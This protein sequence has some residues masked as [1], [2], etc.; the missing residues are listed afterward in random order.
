MRVA[1]IGAGMAGLACAEA[2]VHAGHAVVLFDKGRRPG[3]RMSTRV[4]ATPG[5]PAGFDYGA[6]YM[7]ARDPAFCARVAR[8]EAGGVAARWPAA[9]DDALVGTP[10]MSA[11]VADMASRRDISWSAH[12]TGLAEE[13]DGWRVSG[14]TF[15]ERGF[16]AI[17]VAIP[18]EQVGALVA[19]HDASIAAVA[20]DTPSRPCWT[21][22][23]CFA[24]R[25]P[26]AVDVMKAVGAVGWAARDS[27]KPGR[28]GLETWVIQA[29]PDW[30]ADHLEDR[31][32]SIAPALLEA[33]A[34][35]VGLVLPAPLATYAHRWRYAR[36]GKG[37]APFHWNAARRLGVCGDWCIGPRVEAAWL[38]G[39]KLAAAM[40]G[41]SLL[42]NL[43]PSSHTPA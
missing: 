17:V 18:A 6:Q 11:P 25:L 16:A 15:D 27:A 9:G 19:A 13:A 24:E 34:A 22:V 30:S 12:V 20:A 7:S 37:Q 3:G 8:W 41:R 23:A 32:E 1:I 43:Q 33:F 35:R 42:A 39:T 10:G 5:G 29:G 28:D 2:L 36:S 26:I 4:M 38:S 21:A 40:N 31:R 14:E